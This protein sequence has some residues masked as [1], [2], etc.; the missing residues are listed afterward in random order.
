ML[1]QGPLMKDKDKGEVRG[2]GPC[3]HRPTAHTWAA[4]LSFSHSATNS[5]RHL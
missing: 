3:Q 2:G 4:D 5:L 1:F